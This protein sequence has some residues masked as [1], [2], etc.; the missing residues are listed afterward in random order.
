MEKRAGNFQFINFPSE[1]AVSPKQYIQSNTSLIKE[2]IYTVYII[3]F[4]KFSMPFKWR[5][6]L[7]W[8]LHP[9][10]S[11]VRSTEIFMILYHHIFIVHLRKQRIIELCKVFLNL[12]WHQAPILYNVLRFPTRNT[13]L[14]IQNPIL[15]FKCNYM[16]ELPKCRIYNYTCM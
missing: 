15:F 10:N 9:G 6:P 4:V 8:D 12:K 13:S 1:N 2:S 14:F 11:N 16:A 5:K 7:R 3:C